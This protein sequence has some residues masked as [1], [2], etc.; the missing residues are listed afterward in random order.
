[1]RK[2]KEICAVMAAFFIWVT[3]ATASGHAA[4]GKGI[5]AG[6]RTAAAAETAGVAAEEADQS[7]AAVEAPETD[8]G[9]AAG[10][11]NESEWEMSLEWFEE[12]GLTLGES[13]IAYPAL[14]EGLVA[15]EL[16][17][18]VNSRILEDGNLREYTARISQL[19]SG[20]KMTVSW[21]GT[22]L[23]PVFSFA[24]SAEGAVTSPRNTQV[25]TGGNID[26]R[27]GH[28]IL[29]EEILTDPEAARERMEAWLE[30]EA[31]P[32]LS[33]HLQ[34]SQVTPLPDRF[35]ITERGLIWMYPADQLST[36]SDRAGDILIPWSVI[37]DL[38]DLAED[39]P[40]FAAGIGRHAPPEDGGLDTAGRINPEEIQKWAAAGCFPG[41]PAKLGDSVQALTDEWH[42]LTDPDVYA[43]GRIFSL[44]GAEFQRVMI[45]TDFLSEEWDHSVVDGIRVD[46]GGFFGLTVGMTSRAAWRAALGEPEYTIEFDEERAEAYRTTPGSRDY[47]TC[48]SHRLQLHADGEGMLVSVILS[49]E[50]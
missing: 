29:L 49:G 16:R 39:G 1:M 19:I 6:E 11:L 36:L 10:R 28:E 42:L 45:L 3:G 30:E 25:W 15:E 14:R 24:V 34:N 13:K 46:Q 43:L 41:I 35:R 12:K 48:G 22:V 20:G 38:L 4:E 7:R 17:E 47:Y 18:T 40:L 5:S 50:P 8:G 26:L 44:E 32:E 37:Q 31:A 2:R 27:D 9:Q 33:P 23:G 21:R